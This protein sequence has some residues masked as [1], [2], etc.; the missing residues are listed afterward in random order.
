MN[1]DETLSSK[2]KYEATD[3]IVEDV[4]DRAHVSLQCHLLERQLLCAKRTEELGLPI[5]LAAL[6]DIRESDLREDELVR[7]ADASGLPSD[8]LKC[9]ISAKTVLATMANLIRRLGKW[10]NGE[11]GRFRSLVI[12]V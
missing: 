7:T 1:S 6:V 10:R 9:Q 8:F 12:L 3:H 2:N 4:A 11:V 5:C